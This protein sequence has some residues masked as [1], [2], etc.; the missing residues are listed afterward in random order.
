VLALQRSAGNAAVAA[1]LAR[2]PDCEGECA[3]A[4]AGGA[5]GA[6]AVATAMPR[7][8]IE[9]RV[10]G[11]SERSALDSLAGEIRA[12][13]DA[14]R[15]EP[16]RRGE[17]RSAPA[18]FCQP[19]GLLEMAD[20]VE[21]K[22]FLIGFL[23]AAAT[24]M[25]QSA[26]VGSLW[27]DFLTTT[28]PTRHSYAG[29]A[30]TV[31]RGFETAAISLDAH[32]AVFQEAVGNVGARAPAIAPGG[33]V[34]I[35]VA[36]LIASTDLTINWSNPYDIPG[37]IAGG[38]SG[39]AGGDDTRSVRG[40]LIVRRVVG[41]DGQSRYKAI[42]DFEYFANDTVDFC[43]GGA[44][45]G[46]EQNLT[47]P[48]SRLEATGTAWACDV[49]FDVTY[50]PAALEADLD[51]A[52]FPPD[53]PGSGDRRELPTREDRRETRDD[54]SLVDRRGDDSQRR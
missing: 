35:P 6:P 49:P 28:A 36:D 50:R 54:R 52:A 45:S 39:G 14:R 4:A 1:M 53:A 17:N 18:A 40:D 8:E 48:L 13:V 2:C 42:S 27:L 37:H 21:S 32:R 46:L 10:A 15:A 34:R 29:P 51:A 20:A 25:F 43:P 11:T 24:A 3:E 30:S 5:G 7:G 9:A 44:G 19:Y 31:V 26:E 38:Q 33:E 23:P 12:A 16:P 47:V 22:A 41:V